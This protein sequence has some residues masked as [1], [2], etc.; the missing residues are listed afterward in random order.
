MNLDRLDQAKLNA[1]KQRIEERL[2]DLKNDQLV[3][4]YCR[5]MRETRN[6]LEKLVYLLEKSPRHA[7]HFENLSALLYNMVNTE[8]IKF[9]DKVGGRD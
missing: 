3:D 2:Q 4:K 5:Q 9:Y 8:L 1:L 7:R 6:E